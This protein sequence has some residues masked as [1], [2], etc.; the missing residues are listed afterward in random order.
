MGKFVGYARVSSREQA[1]NLNALEQQVAR[2]KA[3][4]ATEILIDVE[5]G[6][7]ASEAKRL[8][9]HRLLKLVESGSIGKVVITRLDRLGRNL[10]TLRKALELM[11]AHG[12][13][14]VALDESIDMS[15]AAGK[16]QMQML[17]ALA[18]ME[19]DRLS[20][21]IQHGKTHF[22]QQKRASHPPFGYVTLDFK[23]H[24]NRQVLLTTISDRVEWSEADLARWLVDTYI[25]ARSL[26]QSLVLFT[27]KFGFRPFWQP[28][29]RRWLRSPVLLGHLVYYPKSPNPEIH[30]DQHEP[31]ISQGEQDEIFGILAS[32]KV[33]G[34][35]GFMAGRAKYPLSGLVKCAECGGGMVV[36]G[37]STTEIK[38]YT[39]SRARLRSCTNHR[40]TSM[41]VLEL[42]AIEAI[43]AAAAKVA[44]LGDGLSSKPA[45]NSKLSELESQLEALLKIGKNPAIE[46]AI[47]GLR[48]Q[49]I[50]CRESTAQTTEAETYD[51]ITRRLLYPAVIEPGYWDSLPQ[52]EKRDILHMLVQ[53][54]Q[55][56][57]AGLIRVE[58][59]P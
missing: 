42:A 9:F 38:Y 1:E 10:P 56:D 32:N 37:S 3:A 28:A 15:T 52:V 16:F 58:L 40:H 45:T 43:Q 36:A 23:H 49:I 48:D 6:R 50:Q 44:T 17:G 19:S 13:A 7:G 46:L 8:E 11:A 22:R 5:S 20:E 29:F 27:E 31:L 18:E 55:V 14:L 24:L 4:G 51:A 53:A 26:N 21:R 57:P 34:G 41:R 25:D 33:R 47:A 35:F 2:L 39:C 12:V 30:R 59:H 54:V